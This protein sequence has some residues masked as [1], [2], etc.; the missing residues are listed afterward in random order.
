MLFICKL[1]NL[2]LF[3]NV[4]PL[5][6]SFVCMIISLSDLVSVVQN[7]KKFLLSYEARKAHLYTCERINKWAAIM[8]EVYNLQKELDEVC[9]KTLTRSTSASHSIK[10]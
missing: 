8:K 7:T 3:H 2:D 6:D 4:S 1:L 9:F 5:I 10:S